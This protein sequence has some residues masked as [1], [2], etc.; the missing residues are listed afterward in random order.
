MTEKIKLLYLRY[1]EQILYLIFGGLT[2]V[3]SFGSYW[4]FYDYLHLSATVANIISWAFAVLFAFVTNKFFVFESKERQ[5]KGVLFELASFVSCR[6]LTGLFGTL[7][8]FLTVDCG[9]ANG[10]L[11][12]LISSVLEVIL[13]YI[14]S[15]LFVFRKDDSDKK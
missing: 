2:T 5:S 7:L 13:N 12:K 4:L 10:L 8:I 15:K 11:M 9:H 1:K 14:A 3:V 6:L